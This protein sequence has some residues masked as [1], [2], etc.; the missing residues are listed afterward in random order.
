MSLSLLQRNKDFP[1]TLEQA[2]K[3]ISRFLLL[4]SSFTKKEGLKK[5]T[6][7]FNNTQV[8]H[9]MYSML[10]TVNLGLCDYVPVLQIRSQFIC[11]GSTLHVIYLIE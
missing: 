5:F 3:V 10:Y 2:N 6:E 11:D 1:T 9:P 7:F 8:F 4:V